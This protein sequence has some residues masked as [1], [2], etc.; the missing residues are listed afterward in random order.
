[1]NRCLDSD[2][3]EHQLAAACRAFTP[4][5]EI[6]SVSRLTGGANMETLSFECDRRALILRRLPDRVDDA[7]R[8]S[9]IPIETE[10]RLVS[11]LSR[12]EILV[13]SVLAVLGQSDGLGRGYI[14]DRI[15]GE[16]RPK[17]IQ[18]Q[19]EFQGAR[20]GFVRE[21]A[22]Q[23]AR[24]H[25]VAPEG[26]VAELRTETPVD[27]LRDLRRR[28]DAYGGRMPVFEIAF[29]WLQR[30]R[31]KPASLSLVHGDYRLGNFIINEAG[32]AGVLDWEQA[33]LGDPV[34]DIAYMCVPSWRFANYALEAGGI[35]GLKDWLTTYEVLSHR[36]VD[37]QRFQF[38]LV[39]CTLWWGV[40]CME[41]VARWRSGADR[42]L[43]KSVIGTRVSEVELDLLLLL[44]DFAGHSIQPLDFRPLSFGPEHGRTRP[45]ELARAISDWIGADLVAEATGSRKFDAL[46]ARNA[47]GTLERYS[48]FAAE[49][50]D[51]R[52]QRL[53]AI[54]IT[55]RELLELASDD[56]SCLNLSA[57]ASHLRRY[58]LEQLQLDQ[59]GYPGFSYAINKW[60]RR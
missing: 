44:E 26:V 20:D 17:R 2:S 60:N 54:G 47:L 13:P 56:P 10:A 37:A 25:E 52:Q 7:D 8:G 5:A 16:T 6:A 24:I 51:L 15:E 48:T 45:R 34:R 53:A 9:S 33:H 58:V 30:H 31:P 59:P 38:W 57:V 14:M 42:V 32:L 12:Q 43:E 4:T 19:A 11:H 28:Y 39:F 29:N 46:V 55:Q 36:K 49:I 41:M 22:E 35:G 23:L 21:A 27:A 1:M 18:T 40:T 50:S 3:I